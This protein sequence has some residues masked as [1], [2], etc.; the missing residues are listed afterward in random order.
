MTV[1]IV[2]GS[3]KDNYMLIPSQIKSK[4]YCIQSKF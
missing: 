1:K 4:I 2:M 3:N